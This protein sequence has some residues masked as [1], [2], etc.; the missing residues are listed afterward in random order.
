[1]AF[2]DEPA[3]KR[4]LLLLTAQFILPPV[5]ALAQRA[6]SKYPDLTDHIVRAIA[7]KGLQPA[8]DVLHPILLTA[9]QDD[10]KRLAE[11]YPILLDASTALAVDM[12]TE[13]VLDV[14]AECFSESTSLMLALFHV[15]LEG[16]TSPV[17]G[18]VQERWLSPRK[19]RTERLRR[20]G[21]KGAI[22][23]MPGLDWETLTVEQFIKLVADE[24]LKKTF[25]T[26]KGT[27]STYL[28]GGKGR[29]IKS[30]ADLLKE[31]LDRGVVGE[32]ELATVVLKD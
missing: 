20:M 24:A 2:F 28:R 19:G 6:A 18:P 1:M 29:R 5:S 3:W 16:Y 11:D 31:W 23:P 14:I 7:L 8:A 13:L 22:L 10:L 27:K 17:D 26:K 15:M 9:L 30:A 32:G 12:P 4:L 25:L 21:V